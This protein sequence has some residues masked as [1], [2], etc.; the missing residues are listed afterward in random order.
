M[1]NLQFDLS[2]AQFVATMI[3]QQRLDPPGEAEL[4]QFLSAASARVDP[5]RE[6][7][8]ISNAAALF[9]ALSASPSSQ[10]SVVDVRS[11]LGGLCPLYPFC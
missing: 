11:I 1:A 2:C 5:G 9:H 4:R 7:E 6:F 8:A 10:L 3:N